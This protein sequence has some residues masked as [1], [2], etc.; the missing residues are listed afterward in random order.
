MVRKEDDSEY[1]RKALASPGL[2]ANVFDRRIQQFTKLISIGSLLVSLMFQ[3]IP[4]YSTSKLHV[5]LRHGRS[6][7]RYATA[8]PPKLHAEAM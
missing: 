6:S 2:E 5:S 8:D 7:G 1:Q 4:Y 3:Q